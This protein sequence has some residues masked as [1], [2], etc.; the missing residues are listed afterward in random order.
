[1]T[2]ICA[3]AVMGAAVYYIGNRLIFPA[4]VNLILGISI[5]IPIY[6]AFLF[7]LNEIRPSEKEVMRW[8]LEK[9]LLIKLRINK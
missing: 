6:F 5:G 1:M 9:L 8:V 7:L 3:S 2:S 4:A